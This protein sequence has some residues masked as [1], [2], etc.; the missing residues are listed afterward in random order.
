M[1]WR[2]FDLLNWHKRKIQVKTLW[3]HIFT[4]RRY[5]RTFCLTWCQR[6]GPNPAQTLE[7]TGNQPSGFV[8]FLWSRLSLLRLGV[9]LYASASEDGIHSASL[10]SCCVLAAGLQTNPINRRGDTVSRRRWRRKINSCIVGGL[11]PPLT[12]SHLFLS[13]FSFLCPSERTRGMWTFVLPTTHGAEIRHQGNTARVCPFIWSQNGILS[14]YLATRVRTFCQAG[15]TR[16]LV[17]VRGSSASVL[18][19]IQGHWTLKKKPNTIILNR[20]CCCCLQV[21][22]WL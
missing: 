1:W 6:A 4:C 10:S 2:L 18:T 3:S 15:R 8:S 21:T 14:Q 17:L 9:C 16:V 13:F 5:N 12:R 19:K 11:F 7:P 20:T 22:V